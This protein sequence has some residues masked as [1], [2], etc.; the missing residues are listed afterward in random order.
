[1]IIEKMHEYFIDGVL[2]ARVRGYEIRHALVDM[3]IDGVQVYAGD[4]VKHALNF[5]T[6]DLKKIQEYRKQISVR[7]KEADSSDCYA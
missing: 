3:V 1:M 6:S 4:M 5:V 2:H 7:T